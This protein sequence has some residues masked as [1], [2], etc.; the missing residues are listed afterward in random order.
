VGLQDPD[1]DGTAY[2][3]TGPYAMLCRLCTEDA[4]AKR[5][6]QNGAG[7]EVPTETIETPVEPAK[8]GLSFEVRASSLLEVG[9]QL[10]QALDAYQSS[11]RAL[12]EATKAWREAVAQLPGA[13][14]NGDL[15]TDG[16]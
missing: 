3:R 15:N 8:P 5:A 4:K 6:S 10:D 9:R 14:V 13:A 1:C 11:R 7:A 12:E 16:E 2:K